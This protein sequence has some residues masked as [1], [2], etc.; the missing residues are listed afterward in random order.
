[1]TSS[2]FDKLNRIYK[3]MLAYGFIISGKIQTH[4]QFVSVFFGVWK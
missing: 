3:H 1:M 4:K 2:V